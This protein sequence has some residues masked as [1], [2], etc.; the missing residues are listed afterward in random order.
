MKTKLIIS[1]LAAAALALLPNP[2][3]ADAQGYVAGCEKDLCGEEFPESDT[4]SSA[5]RSW[6]TI[7]QIILC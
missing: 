6:C 5:L 2:R 7:V 4:Y 3:P 1:L